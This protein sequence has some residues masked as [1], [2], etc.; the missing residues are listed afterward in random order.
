M[1]DFKPLL[2]IGGVSM[3]RRVVNLMQSAGTETV[4]VTG[5]RHVE[6]EVHLSGCG[7]RFVH[8]PDYRHTQMPDSLRLGLGPCPP[9]AAGS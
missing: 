7:V 5:Y 4:V 1:E 9:P 3:I 6:L 8:N 2:P